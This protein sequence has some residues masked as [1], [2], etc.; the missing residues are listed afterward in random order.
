MQNH[1]WHFPAK[2]YGIESSNIP[3]A[4]ICKWSMRV[5][6]VSVYQLIRTRCHFLQQ[7]LFALNYTAC[8]LASADVRHLRNTFMN[9]PIGTAPL[10]PQRCRCL[11]AVKAGVT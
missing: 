5:L 9:I 7:V 6:V 1:Q 11:T 3:T 4:V 8:D 2:L 10:M